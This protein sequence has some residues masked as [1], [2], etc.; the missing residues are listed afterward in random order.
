MEL[1]V[2]LVLIIGLTML[3]D[4]YII[5]SMVLSICIIS[6]SFPFIWSLLK[7]KWRDYNIEFA[8]HLTHT[9]PNLKQE[10]ALFLLAGLFSNLFVQSNWRTI[11]ID[12]LNFMLNDNYILFSISISLIIVLLAIIGVHPIITVTILVT[13]INPFVF[14]ITNE[15]YALLLLYSWAV[16]NTVTP[17]TTVNNILSSILKEP[18]KK[19]SIYLTV[20]YL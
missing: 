3:A 2:L 6:L 14:N 4:Y 13:S 8:N 7:G 15:Y 10:L 17:T 1:V 11:F 12:L 20:I 19:I 18:L 5:Q 16:A 9:L